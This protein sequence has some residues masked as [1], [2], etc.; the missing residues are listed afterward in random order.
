MPKRVMPIRATEQIEGRIFVI[1]AQKVMLD[2]DLADL[3][4]V[5]TKRFNEQVRRNL[6]RFPKDFMFRLNDRE[7]EILRSQIATSSSRSWGGRRYTP[8]VFTEHGT[9]M[10]ATILNSPRATKLSV[11]IVRAFVRMR[12]LTST[13]KELAAK[14]QALEARIERRLLAQDETIFEILAAIRQLMTPQPQPRRRPIGFIHP[15]EN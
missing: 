1:R 9:I 11:Y 15:K 4:G 7:A 12:E 10:A 2:A 13:H 3:Y 6:S 8:Y 5:S 14:F